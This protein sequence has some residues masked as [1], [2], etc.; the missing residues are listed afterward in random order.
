MVFMVH[1]LLLGLKNVVREAGAVLLLSLCLTSLNCQSGAVANRSNNGSDNRSVSKYGYE[2]V[3]VFPHDPNAFTQGLEFHDGQL[4][5]STGQE[6]RSSLRRIELETGK[7]LQKVDIPS[8]YFAEGLTLLKGRI[9]QLTWQHQTGFI[10]DPV[11]F[12]KI[13]EF[14]YQGEGWGLANDGESLILSDGTNRIR[15]LDP[16][17][18]QVRKTIA[19]F[20]TNMPV[21]N[22]NE[23]EYVRGEIYANIWHQDKIVR[24]DPHTGRITGWVDLGGLL[25]RSEV[26]DEEAVLNGI[27]YDDAKDRLFVTGKLW[28]KIFEIRLKRIN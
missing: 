6:G 1:L 23:L 16:N 26:A 28:P 5:E 14:T 8:P 21:M 19:V 12:S 3:Q 9:Y 7:V 10:Y 24:I 18:F 25:S 20:D 15:F 13:G 2:V 11:S 27:A 22:L 17:N 4:F